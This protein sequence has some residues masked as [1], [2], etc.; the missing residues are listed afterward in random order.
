MAIR[1]VDGRGP[2]SPWEDAGALSATRRQ[3]MFHKILVANRGEIA[4]RIVRACAEMG[5]PSVVAHS[6][7]DRDSLAVRFADE[8]VCVGPGPSARSYLNIP[9]IISA[10]LVRGADAIHPGYGFLAEDQ[11]FAEICQQYGLTFIGPEPE[12]IARMADK[13]R[14]RR[15]MAASGLPVLP[16]TDEP[17]A[18]VDEALGAANKIGYPVILKAA[19][20]GGGRGMRVAHEEN[21]LVRDFAA[22][23]LESRASFA[24]DEVYLERYLPD[25]RHIEVQVLADSF[26][27]AIHLGDRDCSIQRRHQ[28]LIEEAASPGL[29]DNLRQ[30]IGEAAVRGTVETHFT[31]AGTLEFLLDDDG[32]YYFLEMNTRIQVE[33]GVTEMIT[34]V[35]IVKEQIAVAAGQPLRL[36]Q[37]DIALRGHALECRVNAESG[38]D[39]R[40]VTGQVSELLLPGGPGIRVDTQLFTGYNLPAHYDSL[41]AKIMAWGV[42]RS[43]AIARMRRALGETVI[44]G[45]PTTL[46]FLSHVLADE[47]FRH[48]AVHTNYVSKR[49]Q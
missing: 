4:V 47:A 33:H 10:A 19:A 24:N 32:E 6:E 41:V 17:L 14:A 31:G 8:S 49:T 3:T 26:G 39:F 5:I 16:G 30:R 22:A 38:P 28:K 21:D 13:V 12:S 44:G 46:P 34:G 45:F 9:N 11:Y 20:G 23:R 7:P 35:D 27:H 43:E 2:R 18:T 29:P 25:C 36:A 37:S 15:A 40:P 1:A 48:G 42:D